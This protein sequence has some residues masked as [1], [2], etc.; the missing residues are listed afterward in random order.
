LKPNNGTTT[1]PAAPLGWSP[2]NSDSKDSPMG[3]LGD[4]M[5]SYVKSATATGIPPDFTGLGPLS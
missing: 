3:D 2:S 4:K 1:P 5:A